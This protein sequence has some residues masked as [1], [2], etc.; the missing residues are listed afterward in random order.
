MSRIVVIGSINMDLVNHV[1][2]FP[3]PGETVH[4]RGVEF[5]PGGK[6]AN[7]AVAASLAGGGV[8]MIG[9]VGRDSFAQPLLDSLRE[10]GVGTDG[11]LAK[12][13]TSGLA[14]I[15]VSDAGENEIILSEGSNGQVSPEDVREEWLAGAS[16][17]ILQN[18]IPWVANVHAMRLAR[19][20]GAKV[21][22][23]PAPVRPI[24]A[25]AYPLIDLL[26]VNET[27]A[28]GLSGIPVADA[29]DAR[30]AAAELIARGASG[31]L[32]TLG[33]KGSFYA[34]AGADGLFTPARKVR[35]VDTTAAGDTFI[36]AFAAAIAEGKPP[37]EALAF[38]TA[39]SSITVTRKGA[40]ASIP[41]RE[42][43]EAVMATAAK[44][45][46]EPRA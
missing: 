17:I 1:A 44:A 11:V 6:G 42:E 13:G 31:V 10:R 3:K 32:V 18:E 40:Q 24:P 33:S 19:K 21:I 39:A 30:R 37:A 26:V 38:A 34:E 36:G 16:A 46:K 43:I 35:A 12:D 28:E 2:E 15:T 14:F 4:G 41:R 8:E 9:A 5:L 27:E 45:E 22:Y 23:N 29:A 7:Q 25:E 20:A